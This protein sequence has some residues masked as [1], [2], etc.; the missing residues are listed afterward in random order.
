MEFKA[1]VLFYQKQFLELDYESRRPYD[2][3]V[4]Q[5]NLRKGDSRTYKKALKC[6]FDYDFGKDKERPIRIA[7]Y[8]DLCKDF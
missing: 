5:L 8:P 4:L 2:W 6:N 1:K 3:V 7:G